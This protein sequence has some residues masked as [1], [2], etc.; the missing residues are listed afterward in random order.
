M[1]LKNKR[2]I[3]LLV[4]LVLLALMAKAY[5]D[6][7]S[8]EIKYYEIQ[9]SSLGEVLAGSK[10]AFLSDLH[11]KSIGL[12][13]NKILEILNEEKPDLILLTGD[14]ISFKGPYEPVMSF[15][16]QLKAPY[17]TYAVLGNAEYS[18]E[19]G[20]CILCHK[21]K[22]KSLKEKQSP[23]FLRNSF[24]A[25]EFNHR[26]INIVGVDD[27]VNKKSEL[28]ITLKKVNLSGPSILLAHSPEILEEASSQGVDLLLAG[29]NHGGQI[30]ITKYLRSILPLDPVLEFLEGFFQKGRTLM[31]VSRGIGTSYLPFRL[32]S[33]P[34]I[35]FFEFSSSTTSTAALQHRKFLPQTSSDLPARSLSAQAGALLQ[36]LTHEN[37][38]NPNNPTNTFSISNNPPKTIFTGFSFG[39]LLETFDI[40]RFFTNPSNSTN[41]INPTDP[42]NSAA[43]P[44][45]SNTAAQQMLFNFESE[46]DLKRLNWQCHKWFE[47][48]EENATSGKYSLKA[49]IP[50]GQYPGI[51][52]QET[53]EDWSQYSSLKM[54]AFNPAQERITFHIR[55]DDNKS[56]WEYADRFDINVNLKQ[57]MNH[58]SIPTD[59]IRTNIH[60]RPLNL[61]KIKR[62]M[63]F[64]PSNS[65]K[66]E[67]YI[68]YIRLE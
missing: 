26:R 47:L 16:H 28:K 48:S 64:I 27:P 51:N 13:E 41:S 67:L 55:I 23:V 29:H 15:F 49:S 21:G 54:D 45:H 14:Y 9:D 35:T 19:N 30:F 11:M 12:R 53:R 58:I 1:I 42:A 8:I 39:R 62:M 2:Y 20:S 18:N 22:S 10:V 24:L 68:D 25:L 50:P 57:G 66:R 31:Y 59:S 33:K 52:F 4:F 46:E 3:S 38:S 40:F 6:T 5:Y 43:A 60:Q 32:G 44:Q 34:E 65:Q 36:P 56:G 63:V 37:P 61:K 7:N 17:G